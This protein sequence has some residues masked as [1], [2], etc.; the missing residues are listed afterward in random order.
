MRKTAEKLLLKKLKAQLLEEEK[1]RRAVKKGPKPV[2]RLAH[3]ATAAATAAKDVAN[4]SK[5]ARNGA[6]AAASAAQGR[7]SADVTR[8]NAKSNGAASGAAGTDEIDDLDDGPSTSKGVR[9]RPEASTHGDELLAAQL[10]AESSGDLGK[11]VALSD[12]GMLGA[13]GVAAIERGLQRGAEKGQSLEETIA[14][15][16]DNVEVE[17]DLEAGAYC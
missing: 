8:A 16:E 13:A 2:G 10:A 7:P 3:A 15:L 11:S 4:A 6:Q 14:E 12:D 1:A 17:G 9:K 5:A